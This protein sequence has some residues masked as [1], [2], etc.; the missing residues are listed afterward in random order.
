M[1]RAKL[2]MWVQ[3]NRTGHTVYYSRIMF[4][5]LH[6]AHEDIRARAALLTDTVDSFKLIDVLQ[7]MGYSWDCE[8]QYDR[9][10]MLIHNGYSYYWQAEENNK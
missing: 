4:P 7:S 2:H 6:E 9:V 8:P 3:S 10:Y 1:K 5:S